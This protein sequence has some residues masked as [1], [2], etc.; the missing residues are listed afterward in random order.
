M[1]D[2]RGCHMVFGC[3]LNVFTFGDRAI[4]A[5]AAAV[6]CVAVPFWAISRLVL[7]PRPWPC[8]AELLLDGAA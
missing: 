8:R 1:A 7:V 5:G 3:L 2:L 4:T 6:V